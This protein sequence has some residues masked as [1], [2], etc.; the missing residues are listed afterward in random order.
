MNTDGTNACLVLECCALIAL[1]TIARASSCCL[2]TKAEVDHQVGCGQACVWGGT[3]VQ[4]EA[5]RP[6]GSS[7]C[8]ARVGVA[9]DDKGRARQQRAQERGTA[10]QTAQ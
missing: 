5:G 1:V 9:V 8:Y 3:P 10:E 2:C 7:V 4:P 6:F